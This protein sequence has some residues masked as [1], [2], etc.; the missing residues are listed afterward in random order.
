MCLHSGLRLVS[1]HFVTI[2]NHLGA[3]KETV[4]NCSAIPVITILSYTSKPMKMA[5]HSAAQ[6]M[7]KQGKANYV[8]RQPLEDLPVEIICA[9]CSFLESCIIDILLDII[10]YP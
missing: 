10:D 7:E 5:E 9:I 8:R 3:I 4:L 6:M 2:C 1:N